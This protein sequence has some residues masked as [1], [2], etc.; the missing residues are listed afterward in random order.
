MNKEDLVYVYN[1]KLFDHKNKNFAFCSNMNGLGLT[2]ISHK[3]KDKYCMI[4]LI[5]GI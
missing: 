1:G 3:D 4:S 2:E 5:Y